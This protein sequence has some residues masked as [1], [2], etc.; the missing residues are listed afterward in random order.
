MDY[1]RVYGEIPGRRGRRGGPAG[2]MGERRRAPEKEEAG[3]D[4]GG[5]LR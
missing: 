1:V 2:V 4:G 3:G 5:C